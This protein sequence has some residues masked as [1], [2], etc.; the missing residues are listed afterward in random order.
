MGIKQVLKDYKHTIISAVPALVLDID[1][2]AM[3]YNYAVTDSPKALAAGVLIGA[4][5]LFLDWISYE[6]YKWDKGII[7]MHKDMMRSDKIMR[8]LGLY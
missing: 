1:S 6:N 4:G 5:A 7:E 8:E 3:L 2:A